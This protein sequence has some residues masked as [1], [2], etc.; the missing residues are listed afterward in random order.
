[1]RYVNSDD[2]FEYDGSGREAARGGPCQA[3][4]ERIVRRAL[5]ANT[6]RSGL[7]RRILREADELTADGAKRDSAQLVRDI[8]DRLSREIRSR[9][10]D[11]PFDRSLMFSPTVLGGTILVG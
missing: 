11:N 7:A 3:D 8:A 2:G 6:G 1:M 5:R 9:E 10:A 4:M